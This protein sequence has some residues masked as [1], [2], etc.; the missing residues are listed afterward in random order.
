MRHTEIR[1]S[2]TAR[3]AGRWSLVAAA[4]SG[5]KSQDRDAAKA[6]ESRGPGSAPWTQQEET[7][8][9][10]GRQQAACSRRRDKSV[11]AMEPALPWSRKQSSNQSRPTLTPEILHAVAVATTRNA[12]KPPSA[13]LPPE[14]A[15]C[16]CKMKTLL[17]RLSAFQISSALPFHLK[18][19]PRQTKI[20]PRNS[21]FS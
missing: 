5:G 20:S 8:M 11:S 9:E 18:T 21:N 2:D 17:L 7:T 10:G 14:P 12:L 4:R 16:A 3:L 6:A 13:S 15:D 1:R 19:K